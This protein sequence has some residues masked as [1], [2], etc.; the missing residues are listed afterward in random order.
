MV[1]T[2]MKA[3]VEALLS[4]REARRRD[5]RECGE[6][7]HCALD[8]C[9]EAL[10][11]EKARQAEARAALF[12]VL[13]KGRTALKGEV[14]TL[15]QEASEAL[16]RVRQAGLE[17]A[18]ALR[19]HL[20][21]Q[22]RQQRAQVQQGL[23][24]QR[25]QRLDV[26]SH[27][28]R[29]LTGH[30]AGLQRQAKHVRLEAQESLRSTMHGRREKGRELFRSLHTAVGGLRQEVGQAR[31]GMQADLAQARAQWQRTAPTA[32][33]GPVAPPPPV[34]AVTELGPG[35]LAAE[36]SPRLAERVFTYLADRPDGVRVGEMEE[37]LEASRSR[38][39]RALRSLLEEGKVR[40]DD[41]LYFAR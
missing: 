39:M 15:H 29:E 9:R 6:S 7:V 23:S 25:E 12:T 41:D 17:Q 26:T 2:G 16:L 10:Q 22:A 21:D 5:L 14:G 18:M 30:Q 1:T 32:H 13:A 4:S 35:P 11:D 37:H 34:P 31:S 19:A 20:E 28:H 27:L 24:A 8:G 3:A 33:A 40:R 36:G 38:V